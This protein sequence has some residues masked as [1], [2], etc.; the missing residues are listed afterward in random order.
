MVG[1]GVAKLKKRGQKLIVEEK[2]SRRGTK[3]SP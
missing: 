2:A 1:K 3:V